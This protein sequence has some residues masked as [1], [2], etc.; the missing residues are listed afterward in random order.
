MS[1]SFESSNTA[2]PIAPLKKLPTLEICKSKWKYVD[3]IAYLESYK[4]N[5]NDM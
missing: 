2:R 4:P 5:R 3:Q 1:I